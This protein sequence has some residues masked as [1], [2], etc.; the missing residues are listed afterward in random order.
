MMTKYRYFFQNP[1]QSFCTCKKCIFT[2]I[3]EDVPETSQDKFIEIINSD[4]AKT[5]FSS[6]SQF[7]IKLPPPFQPT[8]LC[9]TAFSGLLF[10]KSKYSIRLDAEDD[11][12]CDIAQSQECQIM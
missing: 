12:R 3:V 7:W 4:V 10:I 6:I 11:V 5:D 2:V 9:E 8:Y 1:T